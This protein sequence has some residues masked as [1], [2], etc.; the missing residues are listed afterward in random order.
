MNDSDIVWRASPSQLINLPSFIFCPLGIL[1]GLA[2]ATF[3]PWFLIAAGLPALHLLYR[4]M[5]VHSEHYELSTE[6]LRI[7]NGIFSQEINE[8]ELYRVKD[9][10][11]TRSL[12]YRCFNLSDLTLATSDRTH[13]VI[14]LQAIKN[15]KAVREQLRNFVETLR[16]LRGV[17]EFD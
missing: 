11:A 13:P 5:L 8:L 6:R 12:L 1:A 4:V 15:E 3:N 16:Q 14:V 7:Y 17:R 2:A 9:Y 10:V